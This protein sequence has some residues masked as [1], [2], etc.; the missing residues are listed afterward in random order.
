MRSAQV[1][2]QPQSTDFLPQIESLLQRMSLTYLRDFTLDLVRVALRQPDQIGQL[3]TDWEVTLEEIELAGDE[4]EDIL[5]A[6]K[7][8]Q[9]HKAV[10]V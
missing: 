2:T 10:L 5:T 4:L 8:A 1:L 6:R 3:L 9:R 7:E